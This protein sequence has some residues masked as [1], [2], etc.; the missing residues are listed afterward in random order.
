MTDPRAR[1][2]RLRELASNAVTQVLDEA[3]HPLGDV[4]VGWTA[5]ADVATCPLR[6]RADGE[7][8]WGFPG[9]SPMLAAGA[10]GRAALTHHLRLHGQADVLRS[11]RDPLPVPDPVGAV[12]AWMRV[13]SKG[14]SRPPVSGWVA[15]L[16]AAGGP[17]E[18]AKL[19]ATAA[20][21]GRWL[22]GFVRVMGWPLPPQVAIAAGDMD[23]PL[24]LR[25][26][27]NYRIQAEGACVTIASSPDAL[28]GRISPAGDHRLVVH[29][30][31]SRSDT[32]VSNRA[33]FEAVAAA[34]TTGCVPAA[35][36][37]T[38][39]DTGEKLHVTADDALLDRG[40]ENMIEVVR[41]RTLATSPAG[42]QEPE[43]TVAQ[44]ELAATDAKPSPACHHCDHLNRCVPGQAWLKGPGRWLA[45]LPVSSLCEP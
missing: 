37:L 18:K 17:E 25:W 36:V 40:I 42:P 26:A 38:A 11:E 33:A 20:Y 16:A 9:W 14:E 4:Y 8:G 2:T 13:A 10:V 23:N 29:R 41:Q 7:H 43:G 22:G 31:V 12:R 24:S 3:A 15:E 34:L 6:Y 44:P 27:K 1:G 5:A 39:G 19:A 35:I 32:E 21:A 28:W 45:G 30:P